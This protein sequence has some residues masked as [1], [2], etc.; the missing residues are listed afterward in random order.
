[1]SDALNIRKLIAEIQSGRLRVPNFQ[2]GFVWDPDRVAY[3]MDSIYKGY[4][5]GAI[6]LWRT[7]QTLAHERTLGPFSLPPNQP[8]FPTDYILDGQQRVTSMFGVFQTDIILDQK[9][10]WANIYYDFET[11]ENAQESS[12][13]ALEGTEVDRKRHF[14]IGCFFDSVAYRKETSAFTN[15]ALIEKIDRAQTR[16]KEA[17]V[18]IQTINTEDKTAV[19]IVFERVNQRRVE[20][21]TVQLLSAWTWSSDFDLNQKFEELSSELAPFG[22]SAVGDDKDLLLRCCSAILTTDPSIES[23]INLNGS[24]VRASFET[25]TTGVKGAINFLRKNLHVETLANLP[26][27][28]LLVPLAVYFVATATTQTRMTDKDRRS[29]VKWFWRTCLGRRYNSQPFKNLKDDVI[30]IK[31]LK[32]GSISNLEGTAFSIGVKFFTENIFRM[33]AVLSRA[34]VLLLAQRYPKSFVSGQS[35]NLKAVLKEYNRN[36]FHHIYPKT[37]LKAPQHRQFDDTCLANMCFMSKVDN[38][39]L[40]GSAPSTYRSKM[41]TDISEIMISNA[42]PENTF[43]DVYSEFIIERAKLLGQSAAELCG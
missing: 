33:N 30:E 6:L 35:L 7:Q 25:V 23:L 10:L 8:S 19:A 4:P 27:E 2:R 24:A 36:E 20:L 43:N 34:F 9:P 21:D 41:P 38:N 26:Y 14:P 13:V 18:P 32:D 42:L 15:S 28:N 29:I 17:A 39:I 3:L 37:F 1:M 22:F 12:F 16:F 11:V 31:K 5:F 40:S